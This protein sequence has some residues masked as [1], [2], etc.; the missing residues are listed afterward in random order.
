MPQ[1]LPSGL[2]ASLND[3]LEIRSAYS[4]IL[5]S[6]RASRSNTD[7]NIREQKLMH[8]RILGY[9][10]REGPSMRASE[11]VARE[12]NDCRDDDDD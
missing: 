5:R 10:I 2:P 6:E 11:Y 7:H 4:R 12:V 1:P 3:S 8:A 9:L